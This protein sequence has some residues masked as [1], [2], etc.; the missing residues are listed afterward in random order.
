MA[1]GFNRQ[2]I[3]GNLADD[4][5][6]RYV[7]EKGTAK[8]TFRVIANTGY[9][10]YEHTEGFNVVVWGKRAEGLAPYLVKGKRVFAAG[11]TRT[12]SW[13]DEDGKRRYRTEVVVSPGGGEIVLLWGGNGNGKPHVEPEEPE[14][15]PIPF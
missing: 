11:E 9:G 12:H 15:E 14:E 3:I 1:N 10:D 7:G 2:E 6:L 4:S 8:L 13:E 5:E